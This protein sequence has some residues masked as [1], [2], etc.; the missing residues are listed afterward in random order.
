MHNI[1]DYNMGS[2]VLIRAINKRIWMIELFGILSDIDS[3]AFSSSSP[4]TF[5]RFDFISWSANGLA[6]GL[7]NTHLTLSAV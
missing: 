2:Q 3:L 1:P 7:A 6:D 5:C 4:F